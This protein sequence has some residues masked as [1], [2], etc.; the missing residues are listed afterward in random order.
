[1]DARI[2]IYSVWILWILSWMAAAVWTNQTVGRPGFSWRSLYRFPEVLGFALLLGFFGRVDRA[3]HLYTFETL[4]LWPVPSL[5]AGAAVVL[6]VTGL[7]FAWWARL[8]LGR[9]WS[10]TVTRKE[11]HHL[12]NT[13]PYRIVRHPI[14]TGILISAF[15]TAVEQ[16]T[17]PAV[18]GVLFLLLGFWIKAR[19]EENFLRN[20]LGAEAYDAY[21]RRTAMLVPFVRI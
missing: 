2:A 14:Y 20:E 11:G 10:G 1:M 13:G 17:V 8:H 4:T 9:L 6:C 12:V 3:G 15:A 16:A 18:A 7:A 21:A 5:L 19:L